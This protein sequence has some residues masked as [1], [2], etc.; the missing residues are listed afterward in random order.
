MSRIKLIDRFFGKKRKPRK[1]N[2]LVWLTTGALLITA[3]VLSVAMWLYR[4]SGAAQLDL[5]RPEFDGLREQA[6]VIED[7]RFEA[8]GEMA[9]ETINEFM[10]LFDARAERIDAIRAFSSEPLSDEALNLD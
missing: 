9:Q 6:I 5:S 3:V 10:E 4:A 7:D 2:N 1:V 8:S